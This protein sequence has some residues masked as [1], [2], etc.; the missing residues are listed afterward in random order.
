M[1]FCTSD[2]NEYEAMISQSFSGSKDWAFNIITDTD[3]DGYEL[4]KD[5]NTVISLENS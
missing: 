2:L 3:S 5:N 1:A 4:T